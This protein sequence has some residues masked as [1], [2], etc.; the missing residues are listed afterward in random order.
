MQKLIDNKNILILG[1][2]S[3]FNNNYINDLIND[4]NNNMP[5][6][7][8]CKDEHCPLNSKCYRYT[9]SPGAWQSF[10][11]ESPRENDGCEYFMEDWGTKKDS[12]GSN[13]EVTT[14]R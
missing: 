12:N 7:T 6:I 5:D 11:M 10:F 2:N 14:D 4:K 13:K 3:T 1:T 9:A 8:M